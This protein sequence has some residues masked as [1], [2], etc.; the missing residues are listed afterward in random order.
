MFWWVWSGFTCFGRVLGV[1]VDAQEWCHFC[2]SCKKF[3]GFGKDFCVSVKRWVSGGSMVGTCWGEDGILNFVDF[4]W[5]QIGFCLLGNSVK[6]TS[7][8][9]VVPFVR[10]SFANGPNRSGSAGIGISNL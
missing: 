9:D 1:L 3:V 8:F 6:P 5:F 10:D 4:C 7:N 2:G